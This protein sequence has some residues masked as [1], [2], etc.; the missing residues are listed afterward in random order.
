MEN[1]NKATASIASSGPERCAKDLEDRERFRRALCAPSCGIAKTNPLSS[2]N[3]RTFSTN[4]S[5][6]FR[7]R[8]T[9]ES[10]S[11]SAAR[12]RALNCRIGENK[13]TLSRPRLKNRRET[14]RAGCA[15]YS[16]PSVTVRACSHGTNC[17]I[18]PLSP[19]R[20]G[21][22]RK[23]I[24]ARKG[25]TKVTSARDGTRTSHFECSTGSRI[26]QNKPTLSRK[27]LAF[28]RWPFPIEEVKRSSHHPRAGHSGEPSCLKD[29]PASAS[30]LRARKST[31]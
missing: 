20:E 24:S 22:K 9:I 1:K 11:G 18:H 5:P 8:P 31:F 2:M 23:P 4:R 29:S 26:R 19:A 28:S 15:P 7:H 16:H 27:I 14:S 25:I 6:L 30:K 13:P 3:S 12:T 17:A 10:S 21:T